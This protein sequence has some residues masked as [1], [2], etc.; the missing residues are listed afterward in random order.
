MGNGLCQSTIFGKP[1]LVMSNTR[2]EYQKTQTS[3]IIALQKTVV[4]VSWGEFM[5]VYQ[6]LIFSIARKQGLSHEDSNDITQETIIKAQKNIKKYSPQRGTFRNWLGVITKRNIIDHR[7]KIGRRP[8]AGWQPLDDDDEPVEDRLADK[9][10]EF[11]EMWNEEVR[12]FLNEM[13]FERLKQVVK[14]RDVQVFHYTKIEQW[15]ADKISD[16]LGITA[17]NVYQINRRVG[18]K[19]HEIL[20]LLEDESE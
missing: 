4:G 2:S 16:R 3:L 6:K 11:E 18:K 19:F 20:S 1:L 13:A 8:L 17:N 10:D 15:S 5:G 12:G 7:R 9:K 14:V